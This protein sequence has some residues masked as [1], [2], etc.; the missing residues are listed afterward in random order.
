MISAQ[1][2]SPKQRIDRVRKEFAAAIEEHMAEALAALPLEYLETVSEQ[3]QVPQLKALLA[4]QI[5]DSGQEV[6]IRQQ[7]GSDR[8]SVIVVSRQNYAGYL[9]KIIGRLPA[10][11]ELLA[12]RVFSSTD[13][14]FVIDTFEFGLQPKLT[15]MRSLADSEL[16][17]SSKIASIAKTSESQARAYIQGC[18]PGNVSL[19][20]AQEAAEN[21]RVLLTRDHPNRIDVIWEAKVGRNM[22][23]TGA[24]VQRAR[25]VVFA[26]NS[27]TREVFTRAA[28]FFAMQ[29]IDIESAICESIC[30]ED[31]N[32][33]ATLTFQVCMEQPAFELEPERLGGECDPNFDTDI[34]RA[35]L[36]HFL[37]VDHEVVAYREAI[38]ANLI[39][40]LGGLRNAELC[41]AF[42]KLIHQL[43][44]LPD[45]LERITHRLVRHRQV[46]AQLLS[47]FSSRFCE[48][49]EK[50]ESQDA[51]VK[52][53][54]INDPADRKVFQH[55]LELVNGIDRC[56]LNLP[57]RRVLAMRIP[58]QLLQ[59]S[60]GEE[61]YSVFFVAGAAF[62]G[63]HVRFRDV[64]RGGLRIVKTSN[65]EH[66]LFE[67]ARAYDEVY[68]LAFAQQLKNKDIAEG[69]A[70]A[71]IVMKPGLHPNRAGQDFLDG[72]FDLLVEKKRVLP[73][74][75]GNGA[76]EYLYFGPDENVSN[77]LIDW[78][79]KHASKRNYPFPNSIISSKPSIGISHK[80][81]GVT[82]EGVIVFLHQALLE[83]GIN[84]NRPFSVKLT[85]GPD[86]DVAGNAIR[87]L[88]RDYAPQVKIVGLADG[89]GS[90]VDPEGLEYDEL[91]R[92][93]ENERPIAS[94][95]L[96]RLS[97]R[98]SFYDLSCEE[99]VAKRNNMHFTVQSD[100]F[101]PAG[102]R[103]S[104]INEANWKEYF[105]G[106]GNPRS[107]IIVEGANLFLTDRARQE[108]S[109]RGVAI[110]KDSSANKCGVICSSLEII[111]A[112]LVEEEEIASIR[113]RYIE[114]TIVLLRELAHIEAIS[115]FNEHARSP[116]LTLPQISVRISQEI[117]RVADTIIADFENWPAEKLSLAND[118]I[119]SFLP[120]SLVGKFGEE[121]ATRI[122]PIYRRQ[123]VAAIVSSRLVYREGWRNLSEVEDSSLVRLVHREMT[124]EREVQAMVADV[125]ASSLAKKNSIVSVLQHAGTRSHREL[126]L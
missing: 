116:K 19:L 96:E 14:Q 28:E 65:Q 121:V 125:Q 45:S 120:Q 114:E 97:G 27:T 36:L 75:C 105:D 55:F 18:R 51:S 64:A 61:P 81:F 56:N 53:D 92:L 85:G 118:Y 122:P 102:G 46:T 66:Y 47:K 10:E 69:G 111:L 82:S 38:Q 15:Q 30:L 110:V 106:A 74:D 126:N 49:P 88:I 62:D 77:E 94:F 83:C 108:L 59:H 2:D 26:G 48:T 76:E 34:L 1:D 99:Y 115:L 101:L 58:G 84:P 107:R 50:S 22:E 63:F 12:A 9:A 104:A 109:T 37:R 8:L 117:I 119:L 52:F 11:G 13:K 32:H 29:K 39:D 7:I 57:T 23:G 67:S 123:L 87:F 95:D 79:T 3:A 124:Y 4:A 112:M 103:P 5:C 68:R 31:D 70:K 80:E 33:L 91:M 113:P 89:S 43:F 73:N 71:L 90:I 21:L 25:V 16:N 42:A 35:Q 41:C 93:V 72:I 100:V 40:H 54:S 20:S 98:G 24:R 44:Q 60:A 17:L 6:T 78:V 86:G